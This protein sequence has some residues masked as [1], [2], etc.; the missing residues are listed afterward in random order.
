MRSGAS[1]VSE[2]LRGPDVLTPCLRDGRLAVQVR[3]ILVDAARALFM[4]LMKSPEEEDFKA[5][6]NAVSS[7][8]SFVLRTVKRDLRRARDLA[9]DNLSARLQLESVLHDTRYSLNFCKYRLAVE[10]QR[11][12]VSPVQARDLARA[13]RLEK[14]AAATDRVQALVP[15]ASTTLRTWAEASI[16]PNLQ[17][18]DEAW[19]DL[20][21]AIYQGYVLC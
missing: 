17:Q 8:G 1:T 11:G 3:Y 5:M 10:M 4:K 20:E 6:A 18:I 21:E 7:F 9:R 2:A 12:A 13:K 14:I 16:T 15:G 19:Q